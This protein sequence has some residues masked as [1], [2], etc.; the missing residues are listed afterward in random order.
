MDLL[1]SPKPQLLFCIGDLCN[2]Q[3]AKSKSQ[4][5][6]F[7]LFTQYNNLLTKSVH[8]FEF[9]HQGLKWISNLDPTVATTNAE[10]NPEDIWVDKAVILTSLCYHQPKCH[11]YEQDKKWSEKTTQKQFSCGHLHP[12]KKPLM[13]GWNSLASRT[14]CFFKQTFNFINCPNPCEYLSHSFFYNFGGQV[15]SPAL[16]AELV[17]ALKSCK[18]LQEKIFSQVNWK[19]HTTD[20]AQLHLK[21]PD[22][23]FYFTIGFIF[24]KGSKCIIKVNVSEV[25]PL[26]EPECPPST[27][28]C[29][30]NQRTQKTPDFHPRECGGDGEVKVL[31]L[32]LSCEVLAE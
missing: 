23:R 29:V 19:I 1:S 3:I 10:Q 21:P 24:L 9:K 30:A 11:N 5:C 6:F 12:E 17:P 13:D 27:W 14:F 4:K 26:K 16:H 20:D 8:M 7:Y 2:N 28:V 32:H 31:E 25:L 15:I 18:I 22:I